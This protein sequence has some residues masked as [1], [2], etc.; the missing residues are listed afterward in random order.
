MGEVPQKEIG[1]PEV[2]PWF[3]SPNQLC[4]NG[5]LTSP[6]CFFIHQMNSQTLGLV[7]TLLALSVRLSS[8]I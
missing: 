2:L 4:G 5:Q 3:S 1:G 6:L 8:L 7:R